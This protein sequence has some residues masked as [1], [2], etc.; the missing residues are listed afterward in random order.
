MVDCR[1]LQVGVLV[2]RHCD[3]YIAAKVSPAAAELRVSSAA[4][5]M[6]RIISHSITHKAR[7]LHYFPAETKDQTDGT[8]D[9]NAET[10]DQTA[11]TKEQTA[12]T[13]DQTEHQERNNKVGSHEEQQ[14]TWCVKPTNHTKP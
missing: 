10:K 2:A 9:Q 3:K 6:E 1:T 12:E 8:K 13:K 5:Q 11:E 14:S 4:T 7:L